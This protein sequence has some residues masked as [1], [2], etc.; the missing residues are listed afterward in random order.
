MDLPQRP[1]RRVAATVLPVEP[2]VVTVVPA[3]VVTVRVSAGET[4][5]GVF[6]ARALSA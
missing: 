6:F 5:D 3:A 1:C 2:S 4:I